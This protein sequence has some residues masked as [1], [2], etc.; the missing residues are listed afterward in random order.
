MKKKR[1]KKG[2][3]RCKKYA[4]DHM[5]KKPKKNMQNKRQSTEKYAK[6]KPVKKI[7]MRKRSIHGQHISMRCCSVKLRV[8]MEKHHM[9][10]V[11][12]SQ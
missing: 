3:K 2:A 1:Y 5:Q 12:S 10:N 6:E 7:C 9:S 4:R 8:I 11:R